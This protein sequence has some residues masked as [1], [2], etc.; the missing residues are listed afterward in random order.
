MDVKLL[1]IVSGSPSD[2]LNAYSGPEFGKIAVL[3]LLLRPILHQ[4]RR[5]LVSA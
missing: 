1:Q 2:N 3:R 4:H 5:F